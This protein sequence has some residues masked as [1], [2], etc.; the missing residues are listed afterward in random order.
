[1]AL[2]DKN[3]SQALPPPPSPA[4][5]AIF[6]MILTSFDLVRHGYSSNG[7]ERSRHDMV[8][9]RS[10]SNGEKH[11]PHGSERPH[12]NPFGPAFKPFVLEFVAID[13]ERSE[14]QRFGTVQSGTAGP[15][16][17]MA[18]ILYPGLRND[19]ESPRSHRDQP[20]INVSESSAPRQI[21]IIEKS[22]LGR[23]TTYS[24]IPF[25][26]LVSPLLPPSSVPLPLPHLILRHAGIVFIIRVIRWC[27]APLS[28]VHYTL[29]HHLVPH[30]PLVRGACC[31]TSP[32]VR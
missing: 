30:Q 18:L 11:S 7:V 24:R 2:S 6:D 28:S 9:H 22:G 25:P 26:C 31:A 19:P 4:T 15:C 23:V 32:F 10:K 21:H 8:R 20:T 14:T 3:A 5:Q 16:F 29:F 13:P 12:S 1:M 17:P 27:C